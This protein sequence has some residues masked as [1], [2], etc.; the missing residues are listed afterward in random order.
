MAVRTKSGVKDPKK[1]GKRSDRDRRGSVRVPVNIWVEESKEGDLYFQQTGDISEGG[2][3]FRRTI[4]HPLGTK[5]R[6]RFN[7]PG[8]QTNIETAGEVCST[9]GPSSYGAGI[10]FLDLDP[11]EKEAIRKFIQSLR[12]VKPSSSSLS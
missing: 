9:R 10:R 3:S 11:V 8:T 7:L 12:E 5:V 6:L 1:S 2:I 4:P